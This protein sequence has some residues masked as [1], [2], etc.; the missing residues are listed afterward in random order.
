MKT[1]KL[2]AALLIM[3]AFSFQAMALKE[4]YKK[5][6][7][8]SFDISKDATLMLENKF[9]KI[10]CENWDK[11]SITIEVEIT[12][13]ASNQEKAN[14]IFN[15]IDID[16][17]ATSSRVSAVTSTDDHLF[18]NNNNISIDYTISMPAYVNIDFKHKFGDIILDEVNGSCM[19]DLAYGSIKANKLTSDDNELE[20]SFSE[21]FIGFIKNTEMELK[22]SELEIDE[23]ESMSAESKFSELQIGKIDA[24]T[25]ESGYDEDYIG[26]VRD[27]DVEASFSDVEIRN[28]EERLVADFDYGELKVKNISKSFKLVD[29]TS[30]FS[31]ADLGFNQEA[32]FRLVATIKMGELGYP[33]DR[34]RLT[35][36]DLSFTSNKYEGLIGDNQDTSS[37]VLI[38][39]KNAGVNLFYR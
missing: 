13:E 4:E 36:V 1:L 39:A 24:L 33:R 35:E 38:E 17:S 5:T 18:N 10:H 3:M 21:A 19:I 29:I 30:S 28:L 8:K 2:I 20:I 27:L 14:K 22:Y 15:K 6:I 23:A 37:K 11:N 25:L 16:F 12:V 31:G 34:A 7:N 32:S 26:S 9:G